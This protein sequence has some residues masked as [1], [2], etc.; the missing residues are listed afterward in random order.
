[1]LFSSLSPDDVH[2]LGILNAA[3]S[4]SFIRGV[5]QHTPSLQADEHLDN[6]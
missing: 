6:V 4:L 3:L 5:R 1:M 2:G